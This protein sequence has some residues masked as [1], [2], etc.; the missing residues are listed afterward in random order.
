MA[1]FLYENVAFNCRVYSG[2]QLPLVC[3]LLSRR[4]RAELGGPS[5]ALRLGNVGG[6]RYTLKC[7][8]ILAIVSFFYC[9]F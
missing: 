3:W 7:Y 9:H 2:C 8:L 1:L 6:I 4:L 5:P